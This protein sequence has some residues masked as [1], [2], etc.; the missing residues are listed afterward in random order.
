MIWMAESHY[1]TSG[2]PPGF[3]RG[4]KHALSSARDIHKSID[5]STVNCSSQT[6]KHPTATDNTPWA[7]V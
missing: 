7:D 6:I 5:L 4:L 3:S 2:E 1:I